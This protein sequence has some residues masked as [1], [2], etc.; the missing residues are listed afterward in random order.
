MAA[1]NVFEEGQNLWVKTAAWQFTGAGGI[2]SECRCLGCTVTPMR[3]CLCTGLC[4]SR[5]R[6]PLFTSRQ[7]ICSAFKCATVHISIVIFTRPLHQK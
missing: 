6:V 2:A 3:E 7:L 1:N 4:R 5:V